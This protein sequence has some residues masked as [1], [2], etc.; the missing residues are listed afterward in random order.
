MERHTPIRLGMVGGGAGAFIGDV[1]RI[2]S[3]IDGRYRL[4]AGALSSTPEKAEQS[5]AAV[6]LAEDRTYSDYTEMAKREARLKDGI[7]TVAICTPNHLHVPVAREFLKRGIHVICDKPLS[8]SLAEAKRLR[9][10][11]EKADALFVLTHNYSGYP[12]VRQAKEMVAAGA[13][14]AIRVVQVEYPQD[15]MTDAVEEQGVKQAEWRAD[16]ERAG[17]GGARACGLLPAVGVFGVSGVS[18]GGRGRKARGWTYAASRHRARSQR[19]RTGS[20]R[21]RRSAL[22]LSC[23]RSPRRSAEPS[24]PRARC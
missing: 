16:P 8:S 22:R 1:H 19:C 4:V 13:L 7:E 10:T 5:A 6:G 17:L 23:R 20:R 9:Q 14:G 3:R 15:W 2:A 11:A 18:E 21:R 24:K 12:I